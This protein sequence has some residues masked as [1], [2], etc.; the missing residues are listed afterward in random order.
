[1]FNADAAYSKKVLEMLMKQKIKF[2]DDLKV[3]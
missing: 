1:M 3:I 2:E